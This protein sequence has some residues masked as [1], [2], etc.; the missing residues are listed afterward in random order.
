MA[1]EGLGSRV[2][3]IVVVM[4]DEAAVGIM[5]GDEESVTAC[6]AQSGYVYLATGR[7]CREVAGR[8][9]REVMKHKVIAI[10][11]CPL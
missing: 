10:L 1:H 5:D 2:D 11:S 4:V 3:M 6:E 8:Y 9:E 7:P